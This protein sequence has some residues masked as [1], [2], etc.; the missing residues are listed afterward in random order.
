MLSLTLPVIQKNLGRKLT[1]TGKKT[2]ALKIL[3]KYLEIQDWSKTSFNI[4]RRQI[5]TLNECLEIVAEGNF[6][7]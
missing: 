4:Q 2:Y 5:N 3:F 7:V 1:G 6:S